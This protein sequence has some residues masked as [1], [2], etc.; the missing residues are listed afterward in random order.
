MLA[1]LGAA[2]AVAAVSGV[3]QRGAHHARG[4]TVSARRRVVVVGAGL[5]GLTAARRPARPRG[6]T[7]WCSRRGPGSADGCTRSRRC[8]DQGLHAE[9]GGESIDDNHHAI[10]ALVARFGLHTEKRP[11]NKILDGADVLA[12]STATAR[13][14]SWPAAAGAVGADYV[15]FYDAIAKAAAG[16]D[17]AH[18]DRRPRPALDR[19]S[20][21]SFLDALHLRPEARFLVETDYRSEYNS[22]PPHVSMLFVAQQTNVVGRRARLRGRDHAD[23]RRQRPA[24][25][26][27][28]RVARRRV[29]LGAPVTTHRAASPTA[30]PCTPARTQLRRARGWWWRAPCSRCGR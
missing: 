29:V 26:G 27:H 8:S 28:G 4:P 23:P 21:A 14:T 7:S 13:P 15:G 20:L 18:P 24:A 1:G 2:G 22:E 25:A 6:G 30:R 12:R 9:G 17:P 5:A 16:V 3:Q 10:Q 11:A 19:Q